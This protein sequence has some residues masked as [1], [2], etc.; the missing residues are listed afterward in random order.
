M[1]N[2]YYIKYIKYK[3]KYMNLKKNYQEGGNTID[4]DISTYRSL[5]ND[6]NFPEEERIKYAEILS[7]LEEIKNKNDIVFLS[8]ICNNNNDQIVNKHCNGKIS[9]LLQEKLINSKLSLNSVINR[10]ETNLF[11][12]DYLNIARD[13]LVDIRDKDYSNDQNIIELT[14]KLDH[15]NNPLV[16]KYIEIKINELFQDVEP[17]GNE[18]KEGESSDLKN[19]LEEIVDE[20]INLL[21]NIMDDIKSCIGQVFRN[22]ENI[23][24]KI[25][26]S[27]DST[28]YP[29]VVPYLDDKNKYKNHNDFRLIV[30]RTYH[31]IGDRPIPYNLN[32]Y[33]RHFLFSSNIYHIINAIKSKNGSIKLTPINQ[34]FEND[35]QFEKFYNYVMNENN[36]SIIILKQLS[37]IYQQLK[38]YEE[39]ILE[40]LNY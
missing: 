23:F 24:H 15:E 21:T 14:Q 26:T 40:K 2:L 3:T 12:T 22:P 36:R 8:L 10:L 27:A 37:M 29:A 28:R 7:I 17:K 11:K 18:S 13:K 33:F 32:F 39:K 31:L 9:V 16:K 25:I 5:A 34:F 6:M 38:I 19:S 35:N 20:M 4:E 30:G 1:S